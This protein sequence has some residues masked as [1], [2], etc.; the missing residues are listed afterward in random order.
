T[1]TVS[2]RHRHRYEVNNKYLP[3]LRR[4]G[5]VPSGTSPD[6]ALVEIVELEDHPVFIAC[7]FHPDFKSR[8]LRPHPLFVGLVQASLS[9]ARSSTALRS[10]TAS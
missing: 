4:A 8:P 1:T 6:R 10:G 2:E 7:Q 5:L 3:A 9:R